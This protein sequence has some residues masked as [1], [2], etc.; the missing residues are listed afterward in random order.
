MPHSRTPW[1]KRFF[2]VSLSGIGLLLSAP[3]WVL[4]A[5]SIKLEDGGPVFYGQERVGRG[6]TRFK[7]WKFRSMTPNTGGG[8]CLPQGGHKDKT[9]TT[10][11]RILR[12]T[13]MDEVAPP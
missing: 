11:G 5:I 7:N 2:D 3:L 8:V 10:L 4:I 12:A 6:G 9:G 13:A 1:S